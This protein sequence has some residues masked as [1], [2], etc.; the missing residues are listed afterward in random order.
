MKIGV[1]TLQQ[2][3]QN[4]SKLKRILSSEK[5]LAD[6]KHDDDATPS[7]RIMMKKQAPHLDINTRDENGATP[8]MLAAL[9]GHCSIVSVLLTYSAVV[10]A[11]D[12]QG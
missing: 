11:A 5:S 9:N 12:S 2:I 6:D 1:L 7:L 4:K 8:L 10:G 3:L